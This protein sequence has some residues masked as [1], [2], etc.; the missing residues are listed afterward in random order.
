MPTRYALKGPNSG[1]YS[2]DGPIQGQERSVHG[3]AVPEGEGEDLLAEES[4]EEPLLLGVVRLTRTGLSFSG[5]IRGRIGARIGGI[6]RILIGIVRCPFWSPFGA[7]SSS[8][9]WI[10]GGRLDGRL[11]GSRDEPLLVRLR[12]RLHRCVT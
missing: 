12:I 9:V 10:L 1:G 11:S 3:E 6:C 5:R 7:L 2:S 8:F 4:A